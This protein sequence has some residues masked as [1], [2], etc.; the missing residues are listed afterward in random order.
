MITATKAG[1]TQ[2]QAQPQP[3]AHTA[4]T[5]SMHDST[6]HRP[7]GPR[8]TPKQPSNAYSP[9]STND[10]QGRGPPIISAIQ[11][12]AQT[13][14][15]TLRTDLHQVWIPSRHDTPRQP[16]PRTQRRPRTTTSRNGRNSPRL[17]RL[18]HSTPPMQPK[19]RRKTRSKPN[20]KKLFAKKIDER[21][22]KDT[23]LHSRRPSSL[24]PQVRTGGQIQPDRATNSQGRLGPAQIGN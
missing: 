19:P 11:T 23:T 10:D 16:P 3:H 18:R 6:K 14:P 1:S 13:S 24:S 7:P 12:M 22:F 21:F 4:A 2:T 9:R 20:Q 5:T 17:R 8:A 15:H